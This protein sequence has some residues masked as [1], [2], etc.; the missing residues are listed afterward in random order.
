MRARMQRGYWWRLCPNKLQFNTFDEKPVVY[1]ESEDWGLRFIYSPCPLDNSKLLKHSL[2]I[3]QGYLACLL[4][5]W[6]FLFQA[7]PSSGSLKDSATSL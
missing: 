6:T 3:L 5:A 1:G 7:L 2:P 4:F